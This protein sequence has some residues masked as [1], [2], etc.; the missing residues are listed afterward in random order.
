MPLIAHTCNSDSDSD[1]DTPPMHHAVPT[2]PLFIPAP[3]T[4]PPQPHTSLPVAPQHSSHNRILTQA[5]K[6]YSDD[7]AAAKSHLQSLCDA[8]LVKAS[9][10]GVTGMLESVAEDVAEVEQNM[11]IPEVIANVVIEEQTNVAI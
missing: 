4:S 7:L 9:H 8:C 3:L 10:E 2:T 1:S 6:S 5:G 11:D